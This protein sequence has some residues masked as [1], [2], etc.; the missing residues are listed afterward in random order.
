MFFFIILSTFCHLHHLE[1]SASHPLPLL[2]GRPQVDAFVDEKASYHDMSKLFP[3]VMLQI[4]DVE[5]HELLGKFSLIPL[6]C[7]LGI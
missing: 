2:E 6:M 7:S 3:P 4:R 5:C 1:E